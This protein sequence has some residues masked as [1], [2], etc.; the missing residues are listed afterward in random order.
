M[1][2]KSKNNDEPVFNWHHIMKLNKT[3]KFSTASWDTDMSEQEFPART[4]C[5]LGFFN[6]ELPAKSTLL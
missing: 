1:T 3:E 5:T 2:W 4:L 6:A